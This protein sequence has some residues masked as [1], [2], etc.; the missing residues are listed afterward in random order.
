MKL[1]YKEKTLL[2]I[3]QYQTAILKY[4]VLRDTALSLIVSMI[5]YLLYIAY[6]KYDRVLD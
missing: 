3:F 1:K 2:N 6:H 5:S 4:F